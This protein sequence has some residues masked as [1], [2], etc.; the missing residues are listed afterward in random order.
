[1]CRRNIEQ[2]EEF[3]TVIVDEAHYLK[4]LD[5]KRSETL[6]PFLKNRK[7]VFLLTGTPALAKPKE[8]FNL[9]SI[10]RPDIYYNFK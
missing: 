2:F 10:I 6:V 8:I 3:K 4:T 5:S 1:M 7:R 9:L